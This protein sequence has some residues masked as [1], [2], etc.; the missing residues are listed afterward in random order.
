MSSGPRLASKIPHLGQKNTILKYK[1]TKI[2]AALREQVWM[3]NVGSKFKTKCFVSWC[4]NNITVFD[5]QCGHIQAESNGGATH[6]SNLIPLCSRCNLSMGTMH[7]NDWEQLGS[8][9]MPSTNFLTRFMR[10]IKCF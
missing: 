9:M 6:L 5:F 2:P 10:W 3:H 4:K 1:K 8:K 7:L